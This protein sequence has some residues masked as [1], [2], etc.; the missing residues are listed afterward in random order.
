MAFERFDEYYD[1]E[2][3]FKIANMDLFKVPDLATRAAA[4]EAGDADIA[5]ISL[6][7]K[8]RVEAGGGRLVW[9]PEASYFR[10]QLLG[11]WLPEIPFSKKEVRQ[12]MQYAL[13]MDQFTALYGEEVFQPKGWAYVTPS[14]IGYSTE[15]DPYPYDPDKAKQLMAD[16]GYPNG[17]GFGPLV[18][19]TWQSQ[20]V[21]FMPESA[22]LAAS[23]W[24]AVLGIDAT[25]RVG[26]EVA[27]KQA[28]NSSDTIYGQIV[29]RDNETR[30][31]GVSITRSGF[32]DPTNKGRA[33][34]DQAIF[35]A[36]VKAMA[37][38]PP[39][40]KDAALR[41]LYQNLRDEGYRFSIG[42]V[43]ICLL[44]T[45]PSPRDRQKSRM[46]SSA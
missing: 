35:D 8:G 17:E 31:D 14:A 4:L 12:A 6:D 11:A 25:V 18:V 30:V 44:Y 43:N 9:G 27:I 15:L 3:S 39:V 36:T 32:G 40:E 10:I 46:P 24:R 37:V 41:S 42:Y 26:D 5:P 13:D 2:R 7:T 19:N 23:Q 34:E 21:P 33:H 38:I 16:A 22:E 1:E 45:S 20:G 29:W 28:A